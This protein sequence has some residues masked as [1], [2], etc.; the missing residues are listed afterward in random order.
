MSK[1]FASSRTAARGLL[2]Y[3]V[4]ELMT[5][6]SRVLITVF[7]VFVA[8][9]LGL[10]PSAIMGQPPDTI[11]TRIYE[12]EYEENNMTLHET[13]DGGFMMVG[14]YYDSLEILRAAAFLRKIDG[15]GNEEWFRDY[16]GEGSQIFHDGM[17]TSDGGYVLAGSSSREYTSA[18]VVKTDANGDTMWTT[19]VTQNPSEWGAVYGIDQTEDGGYMLVGNHDDQPGINYY[20]IKLR[21]LGDV[22]WMRSHSEGWE[23]R[24]TIGEFHPTCD[25]GYVLVG[26][27]LRWVPP[28]TPSA[29]YVAKVDGHGNLEWS[30]IFERSEGPGEAFAVDVASNGNIVILT[31]V[32]ADDGT[33]LYLT[34]IDSQGEVLWEYM[35]NEPRIAWRYFDPLCMPRGGYLLCATSFLNQALLVRIDAE[36]DTLWTKAHGSMPNYY[37][38]LHCCTTHE[39]GIG[40]SGSVIYATGQPGASPFLVRLGP[41]SIYIQPWPGN[42]A[43]FSLS[44]NYPNPFNS[45]TRFSFELLQRIRISLKVFNEIGQE[46]VTLRDGIQVCGTYHITFDGTNLPS[47]VYYYRLQAGNAHEARKMVLLK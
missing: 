2:I 17:Q 41:E 34:G 24:I 27:Y 13:R 26:Y 23:T 29:A 4:C 15:D 47:G 40:F 44:Q 20:L 8:A 39:G 46:V 25:G 14:F 38:G 32:D 7:T 19:H 28:T 33:Y 43:L 16:G 22:E 11:W 10:M 30:R 3:M 36:G 21:P 42:P 31:D 18:W 1:S 9:V 35:L 37:S 45:S 12:T 5:F 6:R